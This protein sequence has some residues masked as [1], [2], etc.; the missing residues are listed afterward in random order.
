MVCVP[1]FTIGCIFDLFTLYAIR[2]Y[3]FYKK[4]F[5]KLSMIF[6]YFFSV[7]SF[8]FYLNEFIYTCVCGVCV[9]HFWFPIIFAVFRIF[10]FVF[11]G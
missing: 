8:L 6:S 10:F 7:L 11:C 2:F 5:V 4:I 9:C 1:I 3:L